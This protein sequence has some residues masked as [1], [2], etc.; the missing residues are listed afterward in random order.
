MLE[1]YPH[2]DIL[3]IVPDLVDKV[4]RFLEMFN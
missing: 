2:H 4:V 3:H 1:E